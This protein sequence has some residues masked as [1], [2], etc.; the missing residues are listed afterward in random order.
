VALIRLGRGDFGIADELTRE[1]WEVSGAERAGSAEGYLDIHTLVPAHIGRAAY[2][3]ARG[4]WGEAA[5]FGE[6]GLM[7]A[8]RTGYVV[9]AIHHILP[10]IAEVSIHSRQLT[11]A[12]EIGTRLRGDAEKLGH[13]LALAWAEA[14]EAVL[15][16][17]EGDAKKGAAS[18]RKGAE[19]MERIPLVY[20]ATRIRRQL[21]GR[22]LDVGDR[23]GAVAELRRVH[24][25]FARLEARV[26]L[27][28]TIVQLR[29][30]GETPP[31]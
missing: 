2:Y 26:E 25:V 1:A 4:D 5:R 15:S 12:R 9:W 13:P 6:A 11:R 10:I 29:D 28:K 27:E 24:A 23:E 22:L 8:D 20:E 17:L 3:M 16:W 31:R 7:I 30:L 21:A 19:A 14:C 18:L